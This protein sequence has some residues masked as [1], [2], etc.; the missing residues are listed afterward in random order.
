[1]TKTKLCGQADIRARLAQNAE[2]LRAWEGRTGELA[3]GVR[4][5]L[6]QHRWVL[7]KDLEIAQREGWE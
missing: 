7:E 4:S 2:R 1:M 5:N 6:E 3:N